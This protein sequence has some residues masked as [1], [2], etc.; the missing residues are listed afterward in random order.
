MVVE[1]RFTL[2]EL[3]KR[4]KQVFQTQ[5]GANPFVKR[6]FVE[7]HNGFLD[8]FWDRPGGVRAGFFLGSLVKLTRRMIDPRVHCLFEAAQTKSAIQ[9]RD[10]AL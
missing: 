2:Q 6:V 7:N 3:A 4:F 9:C 10:T 8:T 1:C 5:I